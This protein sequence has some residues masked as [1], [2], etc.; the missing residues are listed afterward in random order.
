M[1]V[2]PETEEERRQR[3]IAEIK[4]KELLEMKKEAEA[5]GEKLDDDQLKLPVME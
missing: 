4:T 3:V 2:P 5:K 1:R